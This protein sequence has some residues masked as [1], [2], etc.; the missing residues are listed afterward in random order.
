MGMGKI[1][2]KDNVVIFFELSRMMLNNKN[3]NFKNFTKFININNLRILDLNLNRINLKHILYK[4]SMLEK[5]N[6][7]GDYILVKNTFN[8]I[9]KF[10]KK[11]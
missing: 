7:I 8:N 6:T 3:F 5:K 10:K 1:L 9:K 2:R 4:F 11:L